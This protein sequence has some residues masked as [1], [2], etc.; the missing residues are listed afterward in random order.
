MNVKITDDYTVELGYI[1]ADG[2][3]Y[4]I[5]PRFDIYEGTSIVFFTMCFENFIRYLQLSDITESDI[6]EFYCIS[7]HFKGTV[8]YDRSNRTSE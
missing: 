7:H 5:Y 3:I 6:S 8:E 1:S 4:P 2:E